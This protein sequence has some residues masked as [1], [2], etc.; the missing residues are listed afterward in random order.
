MG[1]VN[2]SVFKVDPKFIDF[3]RAFSQ[4]STE[5]TI[6]SRLGKIFVFSP[7]RYILDYFSPDR[8]YLRISFIGFFTYSGLIGSLTQ[9]FKL[10]VLYKHPGGFI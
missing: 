8:V 6:F 9:G 10:E 5:E 3:Y 1:R 2:S 4:K 7:G